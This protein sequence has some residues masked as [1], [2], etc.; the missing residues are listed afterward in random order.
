MSTEHVANATPVTASATGSGVGL[1]PNAVG[2]I[3]VLLQAVALMGPGVAVAFG[4]GPGITYARGSFPLAIALAMVGSL[5][6]ALNIGQL[7]AH[8]PSAGGSYSYV[9]NGLGRGLGFLA[10][11]LS[12]PAYL[13]F[14]PLNV[15]AFGYA[16]NQASASPSDP[17]SGVPWWVGGV[18]L[19]VLMG[20]LTFFG[21]RISVRL[22]VVLGTIEVLAFVV[23]SVFLVMNPADGQSL[24]AFTPA[25]WDGGHGGI[26]GVLVGA[27]IGMLAF[28]GFESAA[29]LAEESKNP[30]RIIKPVLISAVLLI[31]AFFVLTSYAGVA[32]YGFNHLGPSTQEGTYLHDEAPWI[33]LAIRA[34]GTSGKYLLGMVLFTSFAANMAAG[35]TA[36]SRVAYAMGRAGALPSAFGRLTRRFRTPWL[37][38]LIGVI[39]ALLVAPW[40]VAVYNKPPNT[41]LL[42]VNTAGYSVLTI[43]IAV[44]LAVPFYYLRKQRSEFRV[45]PHLVVPLVGALLLLV[46]L[47]SPL[48]TTLPP[49]NYPG[50]L[51]QY[52][53]GAIAGGWLLVGI[54]W[55][56]VLRLRNPGALEAGERI[57]VTG[58]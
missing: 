55:L 47:L 44:S 35:Y 22:L 52:L 8:L 26:S 43:Y 58:E 53:G 49:D 7:A 29:L 33:T 12:I 16:L 10:G 31:G 18:F 13:V 25:T 34:W 50:I 17:S 23:L 37:A 9:S 48:F 54:V 36:L 46:V 27:V 57:Y 51:P 3:G 56:L 41:F 4:Y 5:L 15:I 20:L 40:L 19:A 42:L 45:L 39:F 24:Q 6:V 21:V 30:R 1:R 28:T 2:I 38:L 32:G 14:L 11:W